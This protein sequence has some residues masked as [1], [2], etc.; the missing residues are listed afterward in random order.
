MEL[1]Q[2]LHDPKRFVP[3]CRDKN[4]AEDLFMVMPVLQ[5]MG[6]VWQNPGPG[7]TNL[8]TCIADAYMDSIPGCDTARSTNSSLGRLLFRNR[9]FGMT[10][11]IVKH[12]YLVLTA[13]DLPKIVKEAF[14]LAGKL[15]TW[16]CRN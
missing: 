5:V 3:Y 10:L 11:P 16:T 14:Y 15:S 2:S 8:V 9:F 6:S 12:S 1:H 4:K 13:E 7:A